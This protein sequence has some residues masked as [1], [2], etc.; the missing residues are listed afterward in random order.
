MNDDVVGIWVQLKAPSVCVGFVMGVAY[1]FALFT[2]F[3]FAGVISSVWPLVAK[4]EVTFS[5]LQNTTI[6][7][8][9]EIFVVV[10]S[11]PWLLLKQ[12]AR[13]LNTGTAL[14]LGWALVGGAI[15][16]GFFQGVVVLSAMYHF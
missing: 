16:C 6:L 9:F 2:G 5:M 11:V 7:M 1:L 12:G 14:R 15:I 4:R 10:F 8:P 3:V 13:Q